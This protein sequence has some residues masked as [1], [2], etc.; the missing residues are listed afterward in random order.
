MTTAT[1]IYL[2]TTIGNADGRK[3]R[4]VRAANASQAW[5]RVAE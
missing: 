2:V 1:R 4:L 5:R 3:K